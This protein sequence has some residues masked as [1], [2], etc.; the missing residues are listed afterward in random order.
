MNREVMRESLLSVALAVAATV[1]G[2]LFSMAIIQATGHDAG[3]AARALWDGAFGTRR[4]IYL[5]AA[6]MPA[7]VL[8]ALGWIVAFRSRKVNLGLEGQ[9]IIGGIVATLVAVES[10]S[11]PTVAALAVCSVAAMIG[12]ALYAAIAAVLWAKRGVNEIV[13]TLMLT[14]IARQILEWVVRGPMRQPG[15]ASFQSKPIPAV[16]QWPELANG[17]PF[18]ADAILAVVA[19]AAIVF[20]INRTVFGFKLRLTGENDDCARHA[21]VPTVRVVVLGFLL[22][23][24]LA[25]LAGAGLLLGGERHMLTSGFSGNIGFTG[26]VVALVAR[27]SPVG[28]IPAALLFAA[29]ATGG[30]VM[31]ARADVPSEIVFITQGVIVVLVACSGLVVRA[32]HARRVDADD[33]GRPPVQPALASAAD[34]I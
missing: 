12:A 3:A 6:R 33:S 25:G 24:G 18:S 16:F 13:S 28:S 26:I 32:L 27:N 2:V 31:Q 17:T 30:G 21:G 19:V 10:P 9:V 11:M 29:L 8:V 20:L 5:T 7:L 1:A 15:K 22:S 4:Q 23:G 14:F 34:A